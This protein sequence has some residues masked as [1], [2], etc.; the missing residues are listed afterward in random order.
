MLRFGAPGA[1]PQSRAIS[2]HAERSGSWMLPE[3]TSEN[4]LYVSS[5]SGFSGIVR[6]YS[7]PHG[8]RVGALTSLTYAGGECVDS[9]GDV[10]IVEFSG[11]SS[12]GSTVYEY[13]HGGST[14]IATL[15]DPGSG[16]GCAVDPTTGNLAV[17][18]TSDASNP[19]HGYG[20]R[21]NLRW[22]SR[23]SDDVSQFGLPHFLILRIRRPG[24]SLSIG[25]A[26]SRGAISS[27]GNWQRLF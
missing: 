15:A 1:M 16:F 27:P 26:G 12:A 8:R 10:F 24:K 3:A 21:R 9:A 7:Y 14:P 19:D 5:S 11:P 17:A 20:G 4:L 18:N 23:Q 13:A 22:F 2:M 6:V 25:F